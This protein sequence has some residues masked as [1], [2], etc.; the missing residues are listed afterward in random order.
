MA[1]RP[2]RRTRNGRGGG[3]AP[4]PTFPAGE[5][6]SRAFAEPRKCQKSPPLRQ[7]APP[8]PLRSARGERPGP[9]RGAGARGGARGAAGGRRLGPGGRRAGGRRAGDGCGRGGERSRPG[10]PG[11]GAAAAAVGREVRAAA[12]RR[13]DPRGRGSALEA[14]WGL[15]R[16][17]ALPR[18]LRVQWPGRGNVRRLRKAGRL[19]TTHYYY[20]S[21]CLQCWQRGALSKGR[22]RAAPRCRRE[23]PALTAFSPPGVTART[24]GLLCD[25]L[26][27][28]GARP[29]YSPTLLCGKFSGVG[30]L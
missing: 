6:R 30:A 12:L 20:R 25:R 7:P 11:W 24:L 15:R 28:V 18:D 29:L 21:D 16:L 17:W 22:L 5:P 1:A 23:T 8:A 19:S 3:A 13:G 26:A 4:S 9:S 27:E 10:R 14:G 2:R